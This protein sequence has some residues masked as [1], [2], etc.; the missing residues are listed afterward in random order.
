MRFLRHEWRRGSM[1]PSVSWKHSRRWWGHSGMCWLPIG[2]RWREEGSEQWE[3]FIGLSFSC[4]QDF[5]PLVRMAAYSG[6]LS[7]WALAPLIGDD[8]KSL[9]QTWKLYW[10]P[11]I[12]SCPIE[13]FCT[14]VHNIKESKQ[15]SYPSFI[16]Q[17][18]Y[19]L[20]LQ[21][22]LITR[23]HPFHISF[24]WFSIVRLAAQVCQRF[25][26]G[27]STRSGLLKSLAER[28]VSFHNM[29]RE[30][31]TRIEKNQRWWTFCCFLLKC[32]PEDL[33]WN[34]KMM[35]WK[36]IFLFNWVVF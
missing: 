18:F 30:W 6:V 17:L 1:W 35:V 10:V 9:L 32:T 33:T 25:K 14:Y 8:V 22:I 28:V 3:M 4:E 2:V 16:Y 20:I 21:P 23:I 34:L 12:K 7:K 5:H 13:Q 36:M 11:S 19:I 26:L 27:R 31:A 15:L 29:Q 24:L